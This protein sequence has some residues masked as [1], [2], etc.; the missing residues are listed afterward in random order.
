[1]RFNGIS[2]SPG[3]NITSAYVQFQ[4]DEANSEATSLTIQG[5][6]TDN[7][8]QLVSSGLNISSRPRTDA[9]VLWLPV[10]WTTR[11]EA[12]PDQQTPDISSVIQEI[13]SRPGWASGNS[14]VIIVTGTGERTAESYDG[15]QAGAPLLHV[16]YQ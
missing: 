3:A 1:M 10:P 8:S 16:E 14:L 13:V 12:G 2:I 6:A 4:V 11:G 7:A 15:N 9:N 5:E